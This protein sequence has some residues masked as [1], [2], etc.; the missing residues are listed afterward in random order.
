MLEFLINWD[1]ELLLYL[2]SLHNTFFDE[3]MW[4]VTGTKIWIPLYLLIIF[5][6]F[7]KFKRREAFLILVFFISAVALAD[8]IS[9]KLFKEVFERFRP[10]QNP[11]I[12]DFLHLHIFEDG[13][14]YKGGKYGFVSSHAA[15]T[16]AVASFSSLIF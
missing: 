11:A 1:T 5:A 12:S 9:V 6:L 4:I 14:L 15:N 16:F 3:F 8:L 13:G 7:Q 2:N 10:S